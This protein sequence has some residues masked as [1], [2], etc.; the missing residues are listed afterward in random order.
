MIEFEAIAFDVDGTLVDSFPVHAKAEELAA[1]QLGVDIT[2]YNW[3]EFVGM[4]RQT[5]WETIGKGSSIEWYEFDAQAD[6]LFDSLLLHTDNHGLEPIAG[7]DAFLQFVRARSID[8]VQVTNSV[9][10]NLDAMNQVL[11]WADMF[12][13]TIAYL[14]AGRA[15]PSPDPYLEACRRLDVVPNQL[16]VI[17]DSPTGINSARHAAAFAVGITTFCEPDVLY[18]A[19]ANLV[20]DDYRELAY[21]ICLY[22]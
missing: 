21:R 17:E 7:S 6:A 2:Q 10:S 9:R 16:V 11:D 13:T 4:S 15:K 8:R 3:A 20:V 22:T 19:G 14:E 1:A 5:L 12:K 18:E